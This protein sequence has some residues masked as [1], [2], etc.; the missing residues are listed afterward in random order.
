MS[1]AFD[2]DKESCHIAMFLSGV[3][4][5]LL[6]KITEEIVSIPLSDLAFPF[7]QGE[8]I[9]ES[10]GNGIASV[11]IPNNQSKVIDRHGRKGVICDVWETEQLPKAKNH[12]FDI[13]IENAAGVSRYRIYK[14]LGKRPTYI[15]ESEIELNESCPED[16]AQITRYAEITILKKVF[17]RLLDEILGRAT[18]FAQSSIVEERGELSK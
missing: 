2:Y 8:L 16:I 3:G 6:L 10:F 15:V 14:N 4:E 12:W 13:R 5:E 11:H 17:R 18:Q 1:N 7:I 9:N